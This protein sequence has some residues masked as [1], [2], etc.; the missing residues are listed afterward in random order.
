[1]ATVHSNPD[2]AEIADSPPSRYAETGLPGVNVNTA[3]TKCIL[4]QTPTGGPNPRKSGFR[5]T[6]RVRTLL[7]R[8]DNARNHSTLCLRV[9]DNT[10]LMT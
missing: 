9:F 8:R 4:T 1:M 3:S 7:P 6:S 2:V 10:K 5:L